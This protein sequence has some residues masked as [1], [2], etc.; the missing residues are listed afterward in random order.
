MN[1]KKLYKGK[2]GLLTSSKLRFFNAGGLNSS[3][4]CLWGHFILTLYL[5]EDAYTKHKVTASRTKIHF[6]LRHPKAKTS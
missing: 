5:H 2:N 4:L 6:I 1:D 3:H